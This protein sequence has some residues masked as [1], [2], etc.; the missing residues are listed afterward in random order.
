MDVS[1]EDID[2][3]G[4]K[5]EGVDDL[6]DEDRAIL[7]A[8]FSLAGE[9]IGNRTGEDVTGFG[10]RGRGV[11]PRS[12]LQTGLSKGFGFSPSQVQIGDYDVSV[13]TKGDEVTVVV[14]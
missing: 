4:E 9:A 14:E 2:R 5:L 3:L 12:G 8:A 1:R 11:G 10:F 6:T 7:L 13:N